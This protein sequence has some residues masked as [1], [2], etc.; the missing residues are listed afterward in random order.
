MINYPLSVTCACLSPFPLTCFY[1]SFPSTLWTRFSL[2]TSVM[3][4]SEI[5]SLPL[6]FPCLP[7]N[8]PFPV[9]LFKDSSLQLPVLCRYPW[10]QLTFPD[11]RPAGAAPWYDIIQI[12]GRWPMSKRATRWHAT[13]LT[14]PLSGPLFSVLNL[15]K[16]WVVDLEDSGLR[17]MVSCTNWKQKTALLE[18][19]A[20]TGLPNQQFSCKARPAQPDTAA[21]L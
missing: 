6:F 18:R 21:D 3:L 7:S 1:S 12:K 2:V 5:G 20:V 11:L 16:K 4:R 14:Q 9:L 13:E 17:V 8:L 19:D 15:A 10:L